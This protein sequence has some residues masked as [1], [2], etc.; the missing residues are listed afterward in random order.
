MKIPCA[1]GQE[2]RKRLLEMKSKTKKKKTKRGR[3]SEG[4]ERERE[5]R[6][7]DETVTEAETEREERRRGQSLRHIPTGTMAFV[8]EIKN[9]AYFKRFQVKLKRRRQG[10][11][12]YRQRKGLTIQVRGRLGLRFWFSRGDRKENERKANTRTGAKVKSKEQGE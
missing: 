2:S 1:R 10:K 9:K 5:K 11:T 6:R 3:E 8:K 7:E 4:R 12:D